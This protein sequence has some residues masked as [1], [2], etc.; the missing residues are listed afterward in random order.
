MWLSMCVFGW[1]C[2][3]VGGRWGGWVFDWA[4]LALHLPRCVVQQHCCLAGSSIAQSPAHSIEPVRCYAALLCCD[5][6]RVCVVR[7]I[8]R[9]V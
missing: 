5:V 7:W 4:M 1:G 8:R 6:G 9:M 2:L 3:S